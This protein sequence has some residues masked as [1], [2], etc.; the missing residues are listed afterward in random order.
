MLVWAPTLKT[1]SHLFLCKDSII[2]EKGFWN[3][4]GLRALESRGVQEKPQTKNP[5]N[6]QRIRK[7][8]PVLRSSKNQTVGKDLEQF[9]S[10]GFKEV[11]DDSR[12]ELMVGFD[13]CSS[14]ACLNQ[15]RAQ[16]LT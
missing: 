15:K 7:G 2:L 13:V 4:L 8:W 10:T 14:K 11:M 12:I 6:C 9:G 5:Q 1:A 16:Y 3:S